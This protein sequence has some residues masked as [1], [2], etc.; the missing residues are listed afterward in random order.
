MIKAIYLFFIASLVGVE[1]SIGA[2]VAPTIFFPDNL[3]G[4]GV[5]THFKADS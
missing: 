4:S 2:F 1:I 5:L 3:I